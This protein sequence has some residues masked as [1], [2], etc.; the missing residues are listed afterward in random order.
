LILFEV[1]GQSFFL[2]LGFFLWL[3]FIIRWTAWISF[4]W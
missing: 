2:I 1:F 4:S 3:F